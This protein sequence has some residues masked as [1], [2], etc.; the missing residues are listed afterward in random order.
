MP[1]YSRFYQPG[2]T[3]FFTV[4]AYLRR[5]IFLDLAFR[6]ALRDA[7]TITR[8][9]KYFDIIAWV[10]LRDHLHCIWQLPE[11]DHNTSLRWAMI[12]RLVSKQIGD[13]YKIPQTASR[14]KRSESTIWQRRF[15]EHHI[16]S[17]SDYLAHLNYCYMNPVKH[18]L[19]TSVK[20]WK[21]STFHRDVRKGLY[22]I[23]WYSEVNVD[24]NFEDDSFGESVRERT[25]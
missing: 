20:D 3:V 10:L 6:N 23:D 5:P 21:Y 24:N 13:R 8:K 12:K 1:N 15:W 14:T 11:N 16:F 19:V 17:E 4:N 25:L 22:S 7:I 9:E 18:G 2:S